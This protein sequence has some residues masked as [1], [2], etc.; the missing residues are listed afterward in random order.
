MEDINIALENLTAKTKAYFTQVGDDT[1]EQIMV[2]GSRKVRG[3]ISVVT[4]NKEIARL[5]SGGFTE[6]A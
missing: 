6:I 2:F 3:T 5:L 1:V 4:A